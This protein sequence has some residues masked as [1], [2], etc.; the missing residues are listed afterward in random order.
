M[1]FMLFMVICFAVYV[2][3]VMP[4]KRGFLGGCVREPSGNPLKSE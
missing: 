1:A 4:V 2:P 3:V